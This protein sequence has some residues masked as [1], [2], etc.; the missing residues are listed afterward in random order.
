MKLSYRINVK[1]IITNLFMPLFESAIPVNNEKIAAILNERW[2]L[3]LGKIIKA[4]QNHT[5]EASD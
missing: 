5:F 4:S 2:G 3:K 1:I